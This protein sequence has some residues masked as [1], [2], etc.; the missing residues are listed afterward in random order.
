MKIKIDRKTFYA[1]DRVTPPIVAFYSQIANAIGEEV[2][3][4]E[5]TKV[6]VNS[7]EAA[8]FLFKLEEWI[9][10][11]P[12]K[13]ETVSLNMLDLQFG[14]RVDDSVEEGYVEV[15]LEGST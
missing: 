6:R 7:D 4:L 11:K 15:D 10:V 2:E 3:G 9:G 13:H 1:Y 8:F 12:N 5:V 14:P